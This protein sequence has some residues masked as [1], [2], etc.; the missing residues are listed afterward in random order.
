MNSRTVE[1]KVKNCSMIISMPMLGNK[2][3]LFLA[4]ELHQSLW[5]IWESFICFFFIFRE[6]LQGRMSA[7]PERDIFVESKTRR[8]TI[9]FDFF[10]FFFFLI[11]NECSV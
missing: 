11:M 8:W 5:K 3:F 2:P 9:L 7:D 1:L 10:F 6:Q 4:E